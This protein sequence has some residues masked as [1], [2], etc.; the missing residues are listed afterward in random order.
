MSGAAPAL[1][2][3]EELHQD[4]ADQDPRRHTGEDHAHELKLLPGPDSHLV[5]SLDGSGT[6]APA[7][8]ALC[9]ERAGAGAAPARGAAA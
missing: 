4:P 2:E 8:P 6:A 9:E 5:A 7:P 1:A 3:D